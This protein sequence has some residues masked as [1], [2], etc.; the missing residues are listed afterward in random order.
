MK[1]NRRT[2]F[3]TPRP[4]PIGKPTWTAQDDLEPCPHCG[5]GCLLVECEV[6]PPPMLNTPSGR[7]V[8]RYIGCPACP[9]AS[10]A[11]ITA[12]TQTPRADA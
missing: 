2:Y 8:V 6:K 1:D 7:A 4:E 12:M 10:P 11:V 5:C 9:Y 3:N